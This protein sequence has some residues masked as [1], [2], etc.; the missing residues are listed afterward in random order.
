MSETLTI[1]LPKSEREALD[2]LAR[3]LDKS[4]S[5][6]VRDILR[7]ALDER[8]VSDTTAHVRGRLSLSPSGDDSFRRRIRSHNW[9]R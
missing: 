4:V 2:R 6:V 7:E 8:P 5:E 9:R 1:R 3:T